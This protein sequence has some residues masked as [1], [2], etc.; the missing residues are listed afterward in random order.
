MEGL[1]E[2]A[3]GKET[4]ASVQRES[5][6]SLPQQVI[7]MAEQLRKLRE[8]VEKLRVDHQSQERLIVHYS[9]PL[10]QVGTKIT[11]DKY[12]LREGVNELTLVERGNLD[13]Q[14]SERIKRVSNFDAELLTIQPADGDPTQLNVFALNPGATTVSIEDESGRTFSVDV[15]VLGDVRHL[16]ALLRREYQNDNILLTEISEKMLSLRGTVEDPASSAEIQKIAEQ[17]YPQVLNHLVSGSSDQE[18]L[19]KAVQQARFESDRLAREIDNTIKA[20]R[21]AWS[22]YQSQSR[23]LELD[24]RAAE[25]ARGSSQQT[26]EHVQAKS[27]Q[28]LVGTQEVRNVEAKYTAATVQLE[29][30]LEV[31]RMWQELEKNEPDLNPDWKPAEEKKP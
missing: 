29:K 27:K 20:W 11:S 18:N 7:S 25:A 14:H 1:D 24:L 26:L 3:A 5:G 10:E 30:A 21:Q 9:Q 15:L 23:L 19:D 8:D 12:T 2:I 28:G 6:Q 4:T 17:H 16:E 31:I 22:A 13:L